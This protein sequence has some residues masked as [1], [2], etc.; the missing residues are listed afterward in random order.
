M[1][2]LNEVFAAIAASG[3][4]MKSLSR[5]EVKEPIAV[6]AADAVPHIVHVADM[7]PDV[8]SD[9]RVKELETF[10]NM[11]AQDSNE[12]RNKEKRAQI[13]C[14]ADFAKSVE[15]VLKKVVTLPAV[16]GS[17]PAVH[18]FAYTTGSMSIH[19]EKRQKDSTLAAVARWSWC[20]TRKVVAVKIGQ[21][22]EA[23][24]KVG[25]AAEATACAAYNVHCVAFIHKML[26]DM[27]G[28]A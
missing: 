26:P 27:H 21:L 22:Q 10:K 16:E 4:E 28:N 20:G 1:S 13:R 8:E 19:V 2:R 5:A 23:I 3:I 25:V 6:G 15:E 18:L 9:E 12:F 11:Y 24:Q 17:A 7:I 14:R